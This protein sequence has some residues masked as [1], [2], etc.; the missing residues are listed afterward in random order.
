MGFLKFESSLVQIS[1]GY[2]AVLMAIGLWCFLVAFKRKLRK[3][4]QKKLTA[5]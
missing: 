4:H 1:L 5:L 3:H 2:F